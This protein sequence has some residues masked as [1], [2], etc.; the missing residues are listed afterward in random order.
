VNNFVEEKR[1]AECGIKSRRKGLETLNKTNQNIDNI[2]IDLW[3]L[4]PSNVNNLFVDLS[5][6]V[7]NL[8]VDL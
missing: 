8:F 3:V 5:Q 6:N 7:D 2:Y 4:D 1:T